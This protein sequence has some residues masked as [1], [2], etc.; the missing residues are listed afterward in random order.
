[1]KGLII[2]VCEEEIREIMS[3]ICNNLNLWSPNRL[4]W[5]EEF[6]ICKKLFEVCEWRQKK[7]LRPIAEKGETICDNVLV[8]IFTEH[9]DCHCS[10][11]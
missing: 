5:Y 9:K 11:Y 7:G 10:S 3:Y 1:M 2:Y 6:N 4:Y 8:K